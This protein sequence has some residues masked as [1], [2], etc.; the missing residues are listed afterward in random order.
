MKLRDERIT[1]YDKPRVKVI[2]SSPSH[3]PAINRNAGGASE[4]SRGVH[5]KS[6]F[7]NWNGEKAEM[8]E[9]RGTPCPCNLEAIAKAELRVAFVI[10]ARVQGLTFKASDAR[11]GSKP[12]VSV[13]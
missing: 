1:S 8:Q 4:G 2:P 10:F 3:R 12:S 6:P 5:S 9:V 11:A 7:E 13:T